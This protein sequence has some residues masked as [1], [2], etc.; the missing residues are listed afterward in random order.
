[1]KEWM[2]VSGNK[3]LMRK[4]LLGLE[5]S[6]PQDEA[7][8]TVNFENAKEKLG[9]TDK[10]EKALKHGV[11]IGNL[12]ENG[13]L[14][15]ISK[16]FGKQGS[17]G[18]GDEEENDI[19]KY[20]DDK[21]SRK[22]GVY[23]ARKNKLLI[24]NKSV[25][26]FSAEKTDELP[27][28]AASTGGAAETAPAAPT[29]TTAPGS[30][31]K[32]ASLPAI[33]EGEET[34]VLGKK[35]EAVK[36]GKVKIEG[37]DK[38]LD[39]KEAEVVLGIKDATIE[40][41]EDQLKKA[42]PH[43]EQKFLNKDS[44]NY[45]RN[46]KTIEATYETEG[47]KLVVKYDID[48]GTKAIETED[49]EVNKLLKNNDK[50]FAWFM[51]ETDDKTLYKTEDA[52]KTLITEGNWEG[53][54]ELMLG[55]KGKVSLDLAALC[56]EEY[57]GNATDVSGVTGLQKHIEKIIPLFDEDFFTKDKY[58]RL[59]GF[60]AGGKLSEKEMTAYLARA[61]TLDSV[62]LDLVKQLLVDTEK[63]DEV[64][65]ILLEKDVGLTAEDTL[66]ELESQVTGITAILGKFQEEEENSTDK[67]S[68]AIL[69][70]IANEVTDNL[71]T[72]LT[73]VE[74]EKAKKHEKY[75]ESYMKN[76]KYLD[77]DNKID[78]TKAVKYVNV[79]ELLYSSDPGGNPDSK[80][81]EIETWAKYRIAKLGKAGAENAF[82]QSDLFK[83]LSKNE[84]DKAIKAL[85]KEFG[86]I[87]D[88]ELG[89]LSST[90][91]TAQI[92]I[93]I[94]RRVAELLKK[95]G[96]PEEKYLAYKIE[97]KIGAH[98]EKGDFEFDQKKRL[99]KY[100]KDRKSLSADL[101]LKVLEDIKTYC[102]GKGTSFDDAK[103]STKFVKD[104]GK[105][106]ALIKFETGDYTIGIS[107][108]FED[109][110]PRK[111]FLEVYDDASTLDQAKL[112]TI[113][114]G[115]KKGKLTKEA[116][117]KLYADKNSD[118]TKDRYK[119]ILAIELGYI[120]EAKKIVE[121]ITDEFTNE[122]LSIRLDPR[123]EYGKLIDLSG[124]CASTFTGTEKDYLK[125]Q[126][127]VRLYNL[128]KG[129]ENEAQV[130]SKLDGLDLFT[131]LKNITDTAF[132][133]YTKEEKQQVIEGLRVLMNCRG[134]SEIKYTDQSED[135][136]D[137]FRLKGFTFT[138]EEK[139]EGKDPY[140][141][142]DYVWMGK[143]TKSLNKLDKTKIETVGGEKYATMA[144]LLYKKDYNPKKKK[145]NVS[146][147]KVEGGWMPD[148]WVD[149]LGT[150]VE[151]TYLK[152]L[153]YKA[154]SDFTK[155]AANAVNKKEVLNDQVTAAGEDPVKLE[156]AADAYDTVGLYDEAVATYLKALSKRGKDS[157]E[158]KEILG[159]IVAILNDTAKAGDILIDNKMEVANYF[160]KA[161]GFT[162][163]ARLYNEIGRPN[164][165]MKLYEENYEEM[166]A[167][168]VDFDYLDVFATAK[169]LKAKRIIALLKKD[170]ASYF[171]GGDEGVR[172]EFGKTHKDA[173]LRI[174]SDSERSNVLNALGFDSETDFNTYIA[175]ADAQ[176]KDALAAIGQSWF[177]KKIDSITSLM[178]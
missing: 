123:E 12:F 53:A 69:T 68:D 84:Q 44:V 115:Y 6:A 107:V 173:I 59:K 169:K 11:T 144:L 137:Y 111:T 46:D 80:S 63:L 66:A 121:A 92:E 98:T 35:V 4:H 99:G 109:D 177:G 10:Q 5:G 79:Y 122:Y 70:T 139:E 36:G 77:G 168:S 85:V 27:A 42:F 62:E 143:M 148:T 26:H 94:A 50:A 102:S 153:F 146:L 154:K 72:T 14:P 129:K 7:T 158:E 126:A 81:K 117:D 149:A 38:P 28:R 97:D 8:L 164:E 131:S 87:K 30:A 74:Q 116:L 174:R 67:V 135:F 64:V 166:E 31:P 163:A 142:Q 22:R 100:F 176:L 119:A 19:A 47:A 18:D 48:G 155:T 175:A 170:N 113:V 96:G 172:K 118:I 165:L 127:M 150:D 140:D 101:R 88:L 20:Y 83:N 86:K 125:I 93:G 52:T 103:S 37:I 90:A 106:I 60:C 136:Y 141:K 76:I 43:I 162:T 89:A 75:L 171:V 114:Q 34:K 124:D 82:Y 120:G 3:K 105:E 91:A 78:D 110:D 39:K 24:W 57:S 9:L 104:L 95:E 54:L 61:K 151:S 58:D 161:K 73:T 32:P 71:P 45:N 41:K 55:A 112:N 65:R 15:Y 128:S 23:N 152:Y 21:K 17:T 16:V 13:E 56:L 33:K 51:R 132:K 160:K 1:M 156:A 147:L 133:G 178:A 29:S 130:R 159:K 157:I 40:F 134:G 108:H 167:S 138:D 145:N 2:K 49:D 25:I